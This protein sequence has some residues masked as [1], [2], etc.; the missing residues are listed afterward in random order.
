MSESKIGG[1]L[2]DDCDYQIRRID[3]GTC[4]EC[5]A[6]LWGDPVTYAL[7]CSGNHKFHIAVDFC[8]RRN[9]ERLIWGTLYSIIVENDSHEKILAVRNLFGKSCAELFH[10]LRAG[11]PL[12]QG[13]Y[14]NQ[15]SPYCEALN[16]LGLKYRIEPSLPELPN[17]SIC[18]P[19]L[20]SIPY[21][22]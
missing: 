15:L 5:G 8:G 1:T 7:S 6:Q 14:L 4:P 9:C 22:R 18:Y 21:D 20:S 11:T 16:E 19:S 13:L 12:F 3:L 17:I 10:I 2:C